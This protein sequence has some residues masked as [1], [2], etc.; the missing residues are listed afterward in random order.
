M[1]RMVLTFLIGL[2]LGIAWVTLTPTVAV[3][4]A[5]SMT[6]T[7]DG[8]AYWMVPIYKLEGGKHD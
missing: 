8:R 7:Y 6:V 4:S 3:V 1:D 5:K 2:L